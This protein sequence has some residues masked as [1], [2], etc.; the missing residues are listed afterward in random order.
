MTIKAKRFFIFTLI[1]VVIASLIIIYLKIWRPHLYSIFLNKGNKYATINTDKALT[2]YKIAYLIYPSDEVKY[3]IGS[4]Y[5]THNE[6]NSAKNFFQ[7]I[8]N[9]KLKSK[10]ANLYLKK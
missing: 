7:K 3:K 8:D 6:L 4:I 5:L 2:E 1:A 10:I 9:R